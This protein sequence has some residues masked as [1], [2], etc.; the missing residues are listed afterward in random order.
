MSGLVVLTSNY[1]EG[2]F[3]NIDRSLVPP[4]T[5]V[6]GR[7]WSLQNQT[8]LPGYV[9]EKFPLAIVSFIKFSFG[10]IS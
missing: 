4:N 1:P 8:S 3:S 7:G 10:N 9:L 6:V 5:L 2:S